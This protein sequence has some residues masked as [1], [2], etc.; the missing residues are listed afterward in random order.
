VAA[1]LASGLPLSGLYARQTDP[2]LQSREI[3]AEID[4]E[5][6]GQENGEFGVNPLDPATRGPAAQAGLA[7]GRAGL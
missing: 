7:Q 5:N 4:L 2:A 6:F 1:Q 3:A